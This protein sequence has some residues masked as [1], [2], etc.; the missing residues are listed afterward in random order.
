MALHARAIRFSTNVNQTYPNAPMTYPS[1]VVWRQLVRSAD[2]V[3][4]NLAEAGNGSSDADFLNKMRLAL[5]E[6]EE[7]K[8]CLTKI[9]NGPLANA[10]RVHELRLDNETDQL[11]AIFSSIITNMSIRLA[12]EARRTRRK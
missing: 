6:G 9:L 4:N 1:E 5:R 2:S 3:S 8:A 7:S 11:C 10:S 12:E